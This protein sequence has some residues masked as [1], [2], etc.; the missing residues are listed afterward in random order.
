MANFSHFSLELLLAIPP[1]VRDTYSPKNTN[2]S[3]AIQM[4]N[5]L[6]KIVFSLNFTLEKYMRICFYAVY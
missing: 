1:D 2:K 6:L 3:L 5:F 4:S